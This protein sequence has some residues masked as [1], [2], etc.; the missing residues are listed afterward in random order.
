[1]KAVNIGLLALTTSLILSGGDALAAPGGGKQGQGQGQSAPRAD[2]QRGKSQQAAQREQQREREQQLERER[3]QQRVHQADQANAKR[4][5][6]QV[7]AE[8]TVSAAQP[9]ST[10]EAT[11]KK[12]NGRVRDD[13]KPE[14]GDATGKKDD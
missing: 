12:G 2:Q 6:E 4:N 10:A 11:A 5:Q 1:M 7:R 8:R 9:G 3:E 13:S 14:N